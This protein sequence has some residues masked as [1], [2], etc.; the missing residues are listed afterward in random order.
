M[1]T[2]PEKKNFHEEIRA[3]Q[4]KSVVIISIFIGLVA[5]LGIVLGFF[6]GSPEGG[7]IVALF[8]SGLYTLIMWAQG[9]SAVLSMMGAQPVTKAQYPYLYHTIEGLAIAAGVPT[10]NMYVIDDTA[11]NA[12]ATG[13]SPD[14]AAIT[15][16]TGLLQKL[17]REELEGVIAHEM[18]HIKNFDIRVMLLAAVLVGAVTL[19]SDFLLRTMLYSRHDRDREGGNIQI[20][21]IVVAIVLAI[22]SPFIAQLIQ[23]AISRRREYLADATGALLTRYPKG[24]ANALRKISGDPDPLVDRANKA[25]AHMFISTPFRGQSGFVAKLFSTHP[26]IEDRIQRLEAM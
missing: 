12:F 21:L 17:N 16:T 9:S 20:V 3:N 4:W 11:L 22:L 25:T 19:L 14:K 24:L 18:A 2:F 23:L 8:V 10:P 26:P 5:V 15:C 1:A 6:W 13:I 7:L